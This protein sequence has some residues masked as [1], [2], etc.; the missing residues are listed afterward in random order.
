MGWFRIG[1]AVLVG[2]VAVLAGV[3]WDIRDPD[4][5]ADS[6]L[7]GKHTFD[8][9]LDWQHPVED[10][11]EEGGRLPSVAR[12]C[13]FD[14]SSVEADRAA[15]SPILF[16]IHGK[17]SHADDMKT[18]FGADA[19]E[20]A[21]QAGFVVAYPVGVL[22]DGVRSWNAGSVDAHNEADDVGYFTH[23]VHHLAQHHNADPNSVFLAGMSNGGFMANRLACAWSSG[24]SSQGGI[25]VQALAPTLGGLAKMQ[26]DARCEGE[27]VRVMMGMVPIPSIRVFDQVACP[28][29]FWRD[30][31][32]QY[33]C[34]GLKDVPV[35]VV[36]HARDVLVPMDGALITPH[37]ELYPPVAYTLRFFAEANG[38]DYTGPHT[39]TY[40]HTSPDDK[41]DVTVCRSLANCRV[42]TTLCVADQSG[43]NWVSGTNGDD[44]PLPSRFFKWLMSP[45]ARSFDTS[46]EVLDFFSRHRKQV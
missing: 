11:E 31:P 24:D 32:A 14:L 27:A 7:F 35:M 6:I 29:S 4:L 5:K 16:L 1:A 44:P 13:Y 37:G 36:N 9:R 30:A 2:L 10:R 15:K 23:I 38:C 12:T 42:N 19:V 28:Y 22:R 8:H 18:L 41:H 43:H 45:Y 26:Y 40:R 46:N 20:R 3:M 39:E 34:S 17:A 33:G 21:K 25:R